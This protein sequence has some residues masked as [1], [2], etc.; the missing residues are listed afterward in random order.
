MNNNKKN[1]LKPNIFIRI[2]MR[3]L[4]KAFKKSTARN[5]L[6][7]GLHD[8]KHDEQFYLEI[9]R[10]KDHTLLKGRE[11]AIHE[12]CMVIYLDDSSDYINGLWDA[13]RALSP[14]IAEDLVHGRWK[15]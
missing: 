7:W 13:L 5:F 2:L 4:I 8:K 6:A 9:G 14:S 11:S 15:P 12:I 1:D 10:D 3:Y